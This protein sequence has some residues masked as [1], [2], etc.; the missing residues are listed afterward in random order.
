MLRKVRRRGQAAI[1]ADPAGGYL[2][3]FGQAGEFVLNP[4]DAR[5]STGPVR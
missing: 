4:F 1:I 2:A 5:H 3:R